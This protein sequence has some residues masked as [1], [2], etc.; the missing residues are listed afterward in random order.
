MRTSGSVRA[1][2]PRRSSNERRPSTNWW[3]IALLGAAVGVGIL[4]AIFAF[5][6]NRPPAG[7]GQTLWPADPPGLQGRLEAAGL[8]VLNAEG[9]VQHTHQHL[10][11]YVDGAHVTIPAGIGIDSAAGIIAPIHTHDT[12]GI[13]HVESPVVRDF[14]LGQLFAVWGVRFDAHCL[15][16]NC[17]GSGRVL[18]V[19]VNGQPFTGD[20]TTL[21]LQAHAEIVVAIGTAGQLPSPM[22]SSY[23]FPV[24]Y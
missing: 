23:Q 9:Q 24:G 4:I 17:D 22:P 20:P 19:D 5:I 2:S 14:T 8:Q 12:S 16:D 10:D 3:P 15:G 6:S 18:T 1:A 7:G 13:I 11:L 21:V